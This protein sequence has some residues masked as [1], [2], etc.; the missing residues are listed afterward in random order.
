M[1]LI[2]ILLLLADFLTFLVIAVPSL[3]AVRWLGGIVLIMLAL[4]LAQD[5]PRWQMI[6]AYVLTGLFLLVWL[7]QNFAPIDVVGFALVLCILGLAI[8]TALPIVLPVFSF[9]RP[10]GPYAIGTVTYHW[11]DASRH[12]VFSTDK[13][14]KRE[15]MVQVWYPA[16]KGSSSAHAPY[17]QDADA[18]TPVLA[19]VSGFPGFFLQHLKYVTTNATE[20]APV[21]ADQASYPVII[22][23]EGRRGYRQMLTYEVEA[24]VSHGYI[25]VGLDQ[26]GIAATVVFPDGHQIALTGLL[27]QVNSLVDQSLDPASVAPQFNGRT[28]KDGISKYFAQ[29]VSFTLDQLAALNTKDPQ[30]ILSG[31]LDLAHTGVVGFS[32][33]AMV[34]A[35][36]SLRDQRIKASLL[37]DNAMPAAVVKEGL[38][39]PAMWITRP[40]EWM[41]RDGQKSSDWSEKYIVLAQTTMRKVYS[42][43]PADGYFVQIPGTL[44]IDFNDAD[45]I[46]PLFPAVGLSGP[47]GSQRAHEIVNAYAL[48][49]FDNHLKGE[50]AALLDGPST[51]YPEVVFDKH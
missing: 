5:R 17:M 40:A 41:R 19:A 1:R 43:L 27:D 20:A 13:N 49:F 45:L 33:G 46:S 30:G 9:P 35:D 34:G 21:A 32:D 50:P 10:T 23:L 11:T 7:L 18:V 29:D 15:L 8:S 31:K 37:I 14:R 42:S 24:L 2:E 48:A 22:M 39:Q 12:E 51:Q 38:R 44:H 28:F 6:P 25:V 26:P 36:A 4:A 3:Q 47:I 16:R